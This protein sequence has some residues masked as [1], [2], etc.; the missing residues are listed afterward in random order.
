MN[1]EIY[2]DNKGNDIECFRVKNDVNG[3]PRYVMHYLDLD[4]DYNK[5]LA[6]SRSFGGKAYRGSD[7]GGGIVFQSYSL[8][9]TLKNVVFNK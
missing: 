9:H 2:T 7:F 3:N 1:K 5:A 6:K 8:P 4:N